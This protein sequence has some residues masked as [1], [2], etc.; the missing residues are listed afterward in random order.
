MTALEPGRVW[1]L[2]RDSFLEMVGSGRS[3]HKR[4]P[5]REDVL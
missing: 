4:P 5:V 1:S 3:Y 2:E